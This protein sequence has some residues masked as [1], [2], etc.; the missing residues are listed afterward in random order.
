[1][2][3]RLR[4]RSSMTFMTPPGQDKQVQIAANLY[5]DQRATVRRST[6]L[7]ENYLDL[8]RC[9]V[10]SYAKQSEGISRNSES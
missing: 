2:S 4:S 7:V 5:E 8:T 1:V 9:I 3:H 6:V 10:V